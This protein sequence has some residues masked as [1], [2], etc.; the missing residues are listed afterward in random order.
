M[1]IKHVPTSMPDPRFE[2]LSSSCGFLKSDRHRYIDFVEIR[3]VIDKT[4]HLA[5]MY[6]ADGRGVT[7][8]DNSR[9]TYTVQASVGCGQCPINRVTLVPVVTLVTP[10]HPLAAKLLAG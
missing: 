8:S 5:G 3:N 6:E 9:I 1:F 4:K 7:K 10:A 2:V